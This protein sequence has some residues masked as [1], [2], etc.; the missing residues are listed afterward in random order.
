[1]L[2]FG[3]GHRTGSSPKLLA[4]CRGPDA[5]HTVRR[6]PVSLQATVGQRQRLTEKTKD[7]RASNSVTH[8]LYC[9][10]VSFSKI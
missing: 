10:F 4:D 6:E 9:F 1:M 7:P 8:I 2:S 3:G 5:S